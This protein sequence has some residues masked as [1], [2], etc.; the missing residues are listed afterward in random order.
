[1]SAVQ[2]RVHLWGNPDGLPTIKEELFE[3][4]FYAVYGKGLS[5]GQVEDPYKFT[6]PKA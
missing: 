3:I 6:Y 2:L 1:V 5:V 4:V